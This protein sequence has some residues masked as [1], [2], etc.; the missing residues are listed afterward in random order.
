[1][2]VEDSVRFAKCSTCEGITL[3]SD[4]HRYLFNTDVVFEGSNQGH[5]LALASFVEEQT[6][7]GCNNSDNHAAKKEP[8]KNCP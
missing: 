8:T 4:I 1:M 3:R 5:R 2:A 7:C 6:E